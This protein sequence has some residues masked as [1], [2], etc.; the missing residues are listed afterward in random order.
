[1][2]LKNIFV[3]IT[4]TLAA[5]AIA[6]PA[7]AQLRCKAKIDRKSGTIDYF[8]AS[9]G[10]GNVQ[11]SYADLG[12]PSTHSEPYLPHDFANSNTCQSGGKGR[13]CRV[14][15]PLVK[16]GQVTWPPARCITYLYDASDDSRC[17]LF[18]P[19]CQPAK[20]QEPT[21][22]YCPVENKQ[23]S[24][25][26]FAA[27][28]KQEWHVSP[29][30]IARS[31]SAHEAYLQTLNGHDATEQILNGG[32][33]L[34]M[35]DAGELML[36]S[37]NQLMELANDCAA[38]D[39]GLSQPCLEST[40]NQLWPPGSTNCVWSKSLANGNAYRAAVCYDSGSPDSPVAVAKDPA[41][42]L[43]APYFLPW[44]RW[45]SVQEGE[46]FQMPTGCFCYASAAS[47]F[48]QGNP[49]G[50]TWLGK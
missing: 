14:V 29:E 5:I 9:N 35:L 6:A 17:V 49:A 7:Q 4:V 45:R 36:A 18:I 10:G 47:G 38:I 31:F 37:V 12:L 2:K 48:A 24:T 40:C 28:R 26:C 11:W 50:Y 21:A 8:F 42:V 27:Q 39:P 13:R 19:N 43:L 15:D 44:H 20:R 22:G 46:G 25:G 23:G 1:M 34:E 32:P 33:S 30:N 16:G 3:A 41:D